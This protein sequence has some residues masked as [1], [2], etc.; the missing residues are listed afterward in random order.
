VPAAATSGL[1]TVVTP[2]GTATTANTFTVIV[3]PPNPSLTYS[4][5][6]PVTGSPVSFDASS[7]SCFATPCSYRW[8]NDADNSQLGTGSTLSLTFPQAGTKFVRMTITDAR[9]QSASVEQNITVSTSGTPDPSGTYYVSTAGSDS[10]PGTSSAPWKTIQKAANTLTSGQT[11]V[12]NAGTYNERVQITRSGSS[13]NTINFQANG[14][15]VM[16]GFNIQASNVKVTGFEITNTPGTSATDRS[17]G[18]GFYISGTANEVSGN[19]VHNTTAAGIYLTTSATSTTLSSNRIAYAVECGIYIQGSGN[20]IVANDVSHTRSVS[21]SDADGV[22]FFGSGNTVRKNYIHAIMMSD[23]PGQSP[24]ID[25]FQTWGPATNYVFEQNLV[26][27]DP[28]QPQGFTIEGITQPVGNITI[29]NNIFITRGTG[30]QPDANVGDM[31]LVTNVSIVNNTMVSMNGAVEYAIWLFPNLS[32]AV[33][34]NNAIFDHGNS[35]EPYI[36]IESGASGL[37]IG[38]NSISKSNGQPPIGSPNPGDLWM[39]NPLFVNLSGGDF[40]LQLT[41]PLIDRG[42]NLSQATNDYDGVPRPQGLVNDIGAF[43]YKP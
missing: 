15:V 41:S 35:G 13:G 5:A 14:S 40:H 7:S 11:A 30:Y 9:A 39:V 21:N 16:L 38:F 37:D 27:K 10:N 22:R 4:P 20:M 19:Y 26:D 24:H 25:A 32:G 3:P 6:S 29:R 18:S 17:N 31:G 34:K 28:S 42:V 8:T 12:V 23:S 1:L 2:G 36:K 43:E 33:V